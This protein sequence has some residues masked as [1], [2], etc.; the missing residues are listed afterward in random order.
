[1]STLP[2]VDGLL[3]DMAEQLRAHLSARQI[4]DPAFVGIHTGGVWVA[5]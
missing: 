3:A 2:A 4:S 5:E 1:M